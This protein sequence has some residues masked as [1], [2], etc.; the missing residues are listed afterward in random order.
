MFMEEKD[1]A[2]MEGEIEVK[3]MVLHVNLSVI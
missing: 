3:I 1:R 2:N